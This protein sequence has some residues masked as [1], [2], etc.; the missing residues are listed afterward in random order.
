MRGKGLADETRE[1]RT[2]ITPAYAGKSQIFQFTLFQ[3]EDHPRL[4]G[5]KLHTIPADQSN[6]G[7]PP[8]MRGKGETMLRKMRKE[9]I[10]PAYAG[11]RLKRS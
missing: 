4:C 10:T 2:R 11:K 1:Y 6:V 3:T 9:G 8:P 5:E 7:S